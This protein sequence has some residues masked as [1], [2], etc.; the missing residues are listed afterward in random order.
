MEAWAAGRAI[1]ARFRPEDRLRAGLAGAMAGAS[2]PAGRRRGALVRR[3]SPWLRRVALRR[4]VGKR[5]RL[6]GA[7]VGFPAL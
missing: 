5:N 6:Q 2:P 7:G 3:P 1:S 4:M